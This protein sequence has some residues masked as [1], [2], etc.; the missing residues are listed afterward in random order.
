MNEITKHESAKRLAMD[1][2]KS[3]LYPGRTEE[4][5]ILIALTAD[6]LGIDRVLAFNG[7]IQMIKGKACISADTMRAKIYEAGHSL[8]VL[9]VSSEKC[10]V[11]GTRKNNG[12]HLTITFSIEDAKRAEL[13][14]SP[15]WKKFPIS[16]LHARATSLVAR[17]LFPDLLGSVYT[18]DEGQ[19]IMNVPAANRPLQETDL[20]TVETASV[21]IYLSQ[22][23]VEHILSLVGEDNARLEKLLAH[24]QAASLEQVPYEHY[25]RIVQQ[26]SRKTEKK[27]A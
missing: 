8:Q 3:K 17:M 5:L 15:T 9:E 12:D 4:E 2:I 26:L 1:A 6:A 11:K 24:Y 25:Q 16:M 14:G 20:L 13:M 18:E 22:E 27:A 10:T 23:E 21:D 7:K 19:D